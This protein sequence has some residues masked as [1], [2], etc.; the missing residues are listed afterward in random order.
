MEE[1]LHCTEKVDVILLLDGSGSIREDGW[2]K[3][4]SFAKKFVSGVMGTN[5]DAEMSVIL[6]S[7]PRT[8]GQYY[9]CVGVL[10]PHDEKT[11]MKDTCGI[12]T[13]QHFS[14][15]MVQTEANIEALEW[16]RGSTMTAMALETAKAELSL[17]RGG[18]PTRI[19]IVTDGRPI[20]PIHTELVAKDLHQVDDVKMIVVPVSG[21][22]LNKDANEVM[23]NIA[24]GSDEKE[25]EENIIPITDFEHLDEL[26]TINAIIPGMCLSFD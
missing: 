18:V 22:G 23:L 4:K 8:W 15:D 3:T 26:A 20:A 16:P 9:K 14:D 21:R 25:K 13:V 24:S 5:A 12:E 17:S 11:F 2:V 1:P 10:K 7:G 19:V 6:F